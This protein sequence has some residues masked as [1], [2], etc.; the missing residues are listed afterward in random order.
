MRALKNH[1]AFALVLTASCT[2]TNHRRILEVGGKNPSLLFVLYQRG[3]IIEDFITIE[4]ETRG[5][6]E[7]IASIASCEAVAAKSTEKFVEVIGFNTKISIGDLSDHTSEF[8]PEVQFKSYNRLP[9]ESEILYLR[10][11]GFLIVKCKEHG[12]S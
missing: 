8:V 7:S 2:P 10:E 9:E 3:G 6:I 4:L 5:H 11:K 1:L 12:L